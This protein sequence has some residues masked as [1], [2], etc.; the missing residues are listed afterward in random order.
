MR[1]EVL[2]QVATHSR[3]Q[4]GDRSES[5]HSRQKGTH[6]PTHKRI[7]NAKILVPQWQYHVWSTRV[8]KNRSKLQL[9]VQTRTFLREI[10]GECHMANAFDALSAPAQ[11]DPDS[12]N[13]EH[14]SLG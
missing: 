5:P 13:P 6:D 11:E 12:P 3:V 14:I 1:L 10:L 9:G 4:P 8:N 7:P 2:C